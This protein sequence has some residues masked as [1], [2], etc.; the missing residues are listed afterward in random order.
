[1]AASVSTVFDFIMTST[2]TLDLSLD[3]STDPKITEQIV[4]PK[5]T[6][7]ATSTVKVSKQ[8]SDKRTLSAGTDTFDLTALVRSPAPSPVDFTGLKVKLFKIKA[9]DSN[10]DDITIKPNVSNGYAIFGATNELDLPPGTTQYL[11]GADKFPTVGATSKD[12]DVT[13]AQANAI[14]E[15]SMVAGTF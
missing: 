6:L 11:W 2:E 5:G 12:M 9:D 4:G 15:I 3:L 8:F 13:S 1:M 10:T 7:N 14:Y